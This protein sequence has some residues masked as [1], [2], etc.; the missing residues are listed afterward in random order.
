MFKSLIDIEYDKLDQW[1]EKNE[2]EYLNRTNDLELTT[3][4]SVFHHALHIYFW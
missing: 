1:F 3:A 4:D 2:P